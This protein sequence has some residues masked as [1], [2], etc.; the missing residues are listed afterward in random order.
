MSSP[1]LAIF[2]GSFD[3]PHVAHLLVANYVLALGEVGRVLV[4][5]TFE[6]PFGKPLSPFE[7]RLELCRRCFDGQPGVEVSDIEAELSRPSYTVRLL[8]RLIAE[9]PERPLR[10][11]IG[12]DVLAETGAWHDFPRVET[13]AP[14]LV[15]TRAG[16]ERPGLGPAVLPDVS[17]T[18]VRELAWL[19]PR[20][21]LEHIAAANLYAA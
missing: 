12:S 17:S 9:Q 3:P 4:V 7:E 13:L 2:G 16:H 21:V 5:P 10:L 18:R 15:L 20:R 1:A 8:E 6:H 14:P 11:I 19:V